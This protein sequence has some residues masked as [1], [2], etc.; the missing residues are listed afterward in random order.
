M[1]TVEQDDADDLA[2][3]QTGGNK[4]MLTLGDEYA[5]GLPVDWPQVV[6]EGD[7]EEAETE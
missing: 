2:T 6:E 7:E 3:Q 1:S 4:F 5:L